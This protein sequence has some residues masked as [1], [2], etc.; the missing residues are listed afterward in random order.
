MINKLVRARKQVKADRAT[1]FGVA[2]HQAALSAL[3]R[4]AKSAKDKNNELWA[5]DYRQEPKRDPMPSV[6]VSG[7]SPLNF[8]RTRPGDQPEP[9]GNVT[10]VEPNVVDRHKPTEDF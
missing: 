7:Y 9:K 4:A 1:E 5:E 8:N 10:V 3:G 6:T 2:G